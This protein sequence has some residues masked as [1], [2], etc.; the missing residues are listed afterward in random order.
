M[1]PQKRKCANENREK[2]S[3]W[4]IFPFFCSVCRIYSNICITFAVEQEFLKAK[5]TQLIYEEIY[6]CSDLSID[7]CAASSGIGHEF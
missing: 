7:G 1:P 6:Y 3:N 4:H 2:C 5:Q